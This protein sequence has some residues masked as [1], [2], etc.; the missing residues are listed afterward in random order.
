MLKSVS[1]IVRVPLRGTILTCYMT[2]SFYSSPSRHI[3]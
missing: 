2:K 3:T 1:A